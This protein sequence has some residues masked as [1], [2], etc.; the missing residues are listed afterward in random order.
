MCLSN[1][2]KGPTFNDLPGLGEFNGLGVVKKGLFNV[3][4]SGGCVSEKKGAPWPTPDERSCTIHVVS[5]ARNA[6]GGREC[7][8]FAAI[9]ANPS[10]AMRFPGLVRNPSRSDIGG[11]ARSPVA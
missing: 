4:G 2:G 7:C 9:K 8:D 11:A 5:E 6:D 3:V 1:V 10:P